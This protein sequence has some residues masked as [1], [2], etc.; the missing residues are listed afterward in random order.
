MVI[1]AQYAKVN[2]SAWKKDNTHNDML[3]ILG[4]LF[5]ISADGSRFS[6]LTF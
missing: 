6:V 1:V 3:P 4:I 2:P 5:S